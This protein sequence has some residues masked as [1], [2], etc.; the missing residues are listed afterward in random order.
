MKGGSITKILLEVIF[1]LALNK[2]LHIPLTC[3]TSVSTSTS[4][5]TP[6][7]RLLQCYEHVY[8]AT[9]MH[10]E[11]IARILELAGKSLQGEISFCILQLKLHMIFAKFFPF[12]ITYCSDRRHVYYLA[13]DT[14]G[15]LGFIDASETV[16]TFGASYEE[17]RGFI[18]NSVDDSIFSK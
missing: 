7:P 12:L 3:F 2:A 1:S 16:P 14:L 5:S 6:L 18:L 4:L 9:Y 8:R 10:N 15:I 13:H 17:V 11:E